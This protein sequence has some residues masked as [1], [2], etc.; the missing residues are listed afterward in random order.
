MAIHDNVAIVLAVAESPY[1]TGSPAAANAVK[2]TAP[3]TFNLNLQSS[4]RGKLNSAASTGEPIIGA[5]YWDIV[6]EFELKGSGT[7]GTAPESDPLLEAAGFVGVNTPATS[8]VYKPSLASDKSATIWWYCDGLIYKASGCRGN[9]SISG[10]A[11]GA[12]KCTWT[13][14]GFYEATTDGALVASPVYDPTEGVSLVAGTFTYGGYAAVLR[15]LSL[16]M[17]IGVNA[18]L[19]IANGSNGVSSVELDRFNVTG[20]MTVGHVL[21][22]TRA[23]EALAVAGASVAFSLAV[24]SAGNIVT[25]TSS[26]LRKTG[27]AKA[28]NGGQVDMNIDFAMSETTSLNDDITIAFT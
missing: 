5:A 23:F 1:G 15:S 11:G 27:A 26:K 21:V 24:G 12:L 25:I 6:L 28:F 9:I 7:A 19:A 4:E 14:K 2:L 13:G 3:P 17:G 8:E 16:D 20:S 22:A 18:L 10:E